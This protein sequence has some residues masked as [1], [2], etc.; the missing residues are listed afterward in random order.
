MNEDDR[1]T[2]LRFTY[3]SG[4]YIEDVWKTFSSSKWV[5]HDIPEGY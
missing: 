2:G 3:A 4:N 1:M 5:T